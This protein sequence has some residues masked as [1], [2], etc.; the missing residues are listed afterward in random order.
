MKTKQKVTTALEAALV[1]HLRLSGGVSRVELA[2]AMD[3]AP[4]TAGLYIDRLIESGFVREGRKSMRSSGRP[5]VILEL[6]PLAGQFIG[7]DFEASQLS[8]IA[9]DFSQNT[10]KRHQIAIS[11]GDN[12]KSVVKKIKAAIKQVASSSQTLLGIGVAAPGSVE[13]TRGI[14]IHYEFIR[15]WK[16]IPLRDD[17][18]ADFDAPISLE[19]NARAVAMAERLFGQSTDVDNFVCL[20]VRSGI[21]AGVFLQGRLHVGPDSLAGEIGGWPC[22]DHLTGEITTLERFASVQAILRKANE[23]LQAKKAGR[24]K[25]DGIDVEE[26]ISRAQDDDAVINGVLGETAQLLGQAISQINLLLNPEKVIIAGPLARLGAKYLDPIR[27][28]VLSYTPE[29]HAHAPSIVASQLGEYGAAIGAAAM[30]VKNW[31][32]VHQA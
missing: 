24:V 30:A 13:P 31:R 23:R 25:A 10:L 3:I 15:D 28:T 21:G 17:L 32:P 16:N 27:K 8:A 26:L 2:R 6:N 5:P 14:A 9:V 4:S 29:L 12:A 1:E 22:F 18:A 11:A 19:N 7:V 20:G